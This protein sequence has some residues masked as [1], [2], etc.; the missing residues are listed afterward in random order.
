MMAKR[1]DR[2]KTRVPL[3]DRIRQDASLNPKDLAP[4]AFVEQW[5]EEHAGDNPAGR[6][7]KRLGVGTPSIYD[8]RAKLGCCKP[9][10][11]KPRQAKHRT[12]VGAILTATTLGQTTFRRPRAVSEEVARRMRLVKQAKGG[13]KRARQKCLEEYRLKVW[14]RDE[15]NAA[16][17][18]GD[19]S[20]SPP[21]HTEPPD[22]TLRQ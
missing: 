5:W 4:R 3:A 1:N 16:V 18:S 2:P 7:A 10:E 21:N 17:R 15:I 11:V 14:T 8:L 19:V 13:S 6:L 20:P 22:A 12:A 9:P